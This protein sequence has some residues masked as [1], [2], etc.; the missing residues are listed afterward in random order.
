M[1]RHESS[2]HLGVDRVKC[3]I[4]PSTFARFTFNVNLTPI[5]LI[6]GRRTYPGTLEPFTQSISVA[7][8]FLDTAA[9]APGLCS[10]SA[11]PERVTA[12]LTMS[13]YQP[14]SMS[15]A[16]GIILASTEATESPAGAF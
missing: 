16:C 5:Y 6:I 9:S 10:G 13:Q 1:Q 4:C 11:Q 2:V 12:A 7:R 14:V 8:P 15:G 3:P